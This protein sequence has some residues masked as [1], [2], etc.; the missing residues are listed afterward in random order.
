METKI[1]SIC[2]EV[3]PVEEFSL[4][5]NGKRRSD[6]KE[7]SRIRAREYYW[8]NPKERARKRREWYANNKERGKAVDLKC[9]FKKYYGITLEQY[10]EM[11]LAQENKCAI[12]GTSSPGGPGKRLCVD[13]NHITGQIRGLL[14]QKCNTLLGLSDDNPVILWKAIKYLEKYNA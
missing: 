12:C 11:I 1:C 5:K 9:R 3:K 2:H 6:C 4:R 13:H 14:C 7:C 10:D 8:K